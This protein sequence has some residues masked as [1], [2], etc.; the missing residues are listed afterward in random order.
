MAPLLEGLAF[1]TQVLG[2]GSYGLVIKAYLN[3]EEAAVKIMVTGSAD[4]RAVA[5]EVATFATRSCAL[6]DALFDALEAHRAK[7]QGRGRGPAQGA[8]MP[9]PKGRGRQAAGPHHRRLLSFVPAA[10]S[11]SALPA[12]LAVPSR[13]A[14]VAPLESGS[15]LGA[16]HEALARLGA[17]VGGVVTLVVMELCCK[18]TLARAVHRGIFATDSVQ[19][20]PRVAR[21]ALVRTAAE[22]ARALL[23]LHAGGI[24]HG[25]L[26]PGN[27]VLKASR[28][29]R[30]GFTAKVCDF[31]LC[32]LLPDGV[33]SIDTCTWGTL[34]YMAPEA[35]VGHVGKPAD[36]W[37]F[38][39]I[40]NELLTRQLPYGGETEQAILAFGIMQGTLQ[41][42]WPEVPARPEG[43][44]AAEDSSC[45]NP[46]VQLRGLAGNARPNTES[47][48]GLGL[49]P[50]PAVPDRCNTSGLDAS[51]ATDGASMFTRTPTAVTSV[52]VTTNDFHSALASAITT[53]NCTDGSGIAAAGVWDDPDPV[54]P[55]LV[56]LGRRCTAR[57]PAARPCFA[58]VLGELIDMEIILKASRAKVAA[59]S[60][61]TRPTSALPSGQGPCPASGPPPDGQPAAPAAA[62]GA[63]CAAAADGTGDVVLTCALNAQARLVAAAAAAL[64]PKPGAGAGPTINSAVA[65]VALATSAGVG[66]P[67]RSQRYVRRTATPQGLRRM[68]ADQLAAAATAS[69]AAGITGKARAAAAATAVAAGAPEP[70]SVTGCGF[71]AAAERGAAAHLSA[72][73]EEGVAA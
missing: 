38:G 33:K 16:L 25:D 40:L 67:L 71:E 57:D 15:P 18:G 5:R 9:P 68:V 65:A 52:T 43:G 35:M 14:L 44:P 24:V 56:N 63:A 70:H 72:A 73:A 1:S 20:P 46:L 61:P 51:C 22:V 26:K 7:A 49:G 48:L 11:P 59:K 69:A 45:G 58:E 3:G 64:A 34:S 66:G 62:S 19:W 13:A 53:C 12:S 32:H 47:V 2:A 10:C 37:S 17:R 39:V 30:R 50:A 28:T 29:D 6:T 41:L 27:V 31:G 21:R 36:V 55:C 4:D 42:Q 54:L 60:V 23:H 8:P